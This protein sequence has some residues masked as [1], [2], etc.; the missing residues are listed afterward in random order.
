MLTN[1]LSSRIIRTRVII[2]SSTCLLMILAPLVTGCPSD[3]VFKQSV[4]KG[5]F[6]YLSNPAKSRLTLD[7]I[8]DLMSF[9]LSTPNV[10]VYSCNS[11]AGNE[12][13]SSMEVILNKTQRIAN[14]VI[15]VCSDGTQYG[16]CSGTKP[17]FCYSGM[18]KPMC[19]GPDQISGTDDDCGCVSAFQIC[20]PDGTCTVGTVNCIN[21]IDCGSSGISA[22]LCINN[23]VFHTRINFTCNNK[24]TASSFCSYMNSTELVMSCTACADGA[25][26]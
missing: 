4:K 3:Q 19:G 11:I 6:N 7:E 21:D 20:L 10:S 15:P 26:V 22:P 14:D 2:V 5:L 18:L 12:S 16:S 1:C 17:G 24:G 23:S 25:C 8:K 13:G 9:Y